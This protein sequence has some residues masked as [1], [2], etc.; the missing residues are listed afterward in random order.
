MKTKKMPILN[1]KS[2]VK[3]PRRTPFGVP[4]PEGILSPHHT[5]CQRGPE[6]EKGPDF[7]ELIS[8]LPRLLLFLPIVCLASCATGF[9]YVDPLEESR[10]TEQEERRV[11]S[12]QTAWDRAL[13]DEAPTYP[14]W[15]GDEWF[16]NRF[17]KEH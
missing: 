2:G 11:N 8:E 12:Y 13:E 9:Y 14:E 1:G 16:G 3:R 4:H 7:P 5:H 6:P 15:G 10:L 17:G